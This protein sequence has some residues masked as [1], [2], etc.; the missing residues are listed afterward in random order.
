M[1]FWQMFQTTHVHNHFSLSEDGED[2]GNATVWYPDLSSIQQI[3]LAIL[4]KSGPCLNWGS[5]A[6]TVNDDNNNNKNHQLVTMAWYQPGLKQNRK[7]LYNLHHPGT[8]PATVRAN[9]DGTFLL[10]VSAVTLQLMTIATIGY[11]QFSSSKDAIWKKL[12]QTDKWLP[13]NR[14]P[15]PPPSNTNKLCYG[16]HKKEQCSSTSSSAFSVFIN[17]YSPLVICLKTHTHKNTHTH[18][19]QH[20]ICHEHF[21]LMKLPSSSFHRLANKLFLGCGPCVLLASDQRLTC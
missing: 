16:G 12:W 19:Q 2:V 3:C 7:S 14:P 11:K 4:W 17:S 20:Q 5:I 1:K 13:Y 21:L 9:G 6:S 18:T 8:H 15:P 10:P